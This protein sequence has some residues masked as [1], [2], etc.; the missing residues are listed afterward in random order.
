[1]RQGAIARGRYANLKKAV[2]VSISPRLGSRL[3][4]TLRVVDIED[5]FHALVREDHLAPT[6]ARGRLEALSGVYRFAIKRGWAKQNVASEAIDGIG[7]IRRTRVSTFT[8][9]QIGLLLGAVT[10]RLPRSRERSFHTTRCA[11]H[12][13]I[14]CGL[15]LGEILALK[16]EHVRFDLGLIEVRHSLDG[17]RQIK[18][19][20]TEAGI[21]DV[22]MPKHLAQHL[23]ECLERCYLPGERDLVFTSMRGEPLATSSFRYEIWYPTLAR[24]GLF[25]QKGG[26]QYHFHALRHFASSYMIA[27]NVAL[28]DVAEMLG[29]SNFDMTLRVYAHAISTPQHRSDA[30]E[31]MSSALLFAPLTIELTPNDGA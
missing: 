27:N 30:F 12:L 28:P 16:R 19:P 20:K 24:A 15:R 25:N 14:F 6:T 21:R 8:T 11:V 31:R 23:R 26:K 4:H 9:A 1:M 3:M 29:H 10:T 18:G 7:A 13:A 17:W 22:P 2:D 5:W